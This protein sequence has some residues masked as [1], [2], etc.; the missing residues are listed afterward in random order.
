MLD[1]LTVLA[2]NLEHGSNQRESILIVKRLH[3][4]G[5]VL[6]EN[7]GSHTSFLGG[8]RNGLSTGNQSVAIR[9]RNALDHIGARSQV[10][11][12]HRAVAAGSNSL[13]HLSVGGVPQLIGSTRNRDVCTTHVAVGND[14]GLGTVDEG[15]LSHSTSTD[16][17]GLSGTGNHV[18]IRGGLLLDYIVAV[19]QVGNQ[20][21]TGSA[22]LVGADLVA[23][24]VAQ[25]KGAVGQSLAILR[26][27]IDGQTGTDGGGEHTINIGVGGNHD[28]HRSSVHRV[29]AG[30]TGDN[31]SVVAGSKASKSHTALGVGGLGTGGNLI[32]LRV[33]SNLGTGNGLTGQRI[34]NQ[35]GHRPRTVGPKVTHDSAVVAR[36]DSEGSALQTTNIALRH[37]GLGQ[38]VLTSLKV[39]H[40]S[41]TIGVGLDLAVND[42]PR[43]RSQASQSKPGPL[44]RLAGLILHVVD[45]Q[46]RL[47][48]AGK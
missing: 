34:G 37:K 18:T 24:L 27:S 30:H 21:R 40:C 45:N 28:G 2:A 22:S 46:G 33:Q 7:K 1:N 23:I 47:L 32:A 8:H 44:N 38:S 6:V 36:P 10:I 29:A 42:L 17:D 4:D 31:C 48:A 16:A 39:G 25:G 13:E 15:H 43:S 35:N 11:E 14:V 12:N 41:N 3:N 26:L 20:N 19:S 5:G 9:H